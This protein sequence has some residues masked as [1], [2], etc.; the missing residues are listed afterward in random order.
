MVKAKAPVAFHSRATAW[1]SADGLNQQQAAAA[2]ISAVIDSNISAADLLVGL[3][4]YRATAAA[5]P[6]DVSAWI[7]GGVAA[8]QIVN[9]GPSGTRNR[10]AIAYWLNPVKGSPTMTA[11]WS[12]SSDAYMSYIAFR[13]V[14]RAAPV[15]TAH[16]VSGTSGTSVQIASA[17]DDATVAV[18][19]TDG[20]IP[21]TNFNKLFATAPLLPGAAAS[22]Q[23]GGTLNDH[24]FTGAG[25]S[26]PVWAA[27]HIAAE[28]VMRF[29]RRRR[30]SRDGLGP[31]STARWA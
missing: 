22:W 28:S 12:L 23:L 6:G 7:L 29:V 31:M 5:D 4:M 24:T 25:G 13:Y 27:I 17:P 20:S 8:N 9:A 15:I 21:T 16:T 30:R 18:W 3:L 10:A 2:T 19:G 11:A 26:A 1:N 14:D